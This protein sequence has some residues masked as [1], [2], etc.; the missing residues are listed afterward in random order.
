[1]STTISGCKRARHNLPHALTTWQVSKM[2]ESPLIGSGEC[3]EIVS[4]R[5]SESSQQQ[6]LA[7]GSVSSVGTS[8]NDFDTVGG[9][10][11]DD[12][13]D[14]IQPITAEQLIASAGSGMNK[15]PKKALPEQPH[16][17]KKLGFHLDHLG[18][19]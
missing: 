14:P 4:V 3:A 6:S 11:E 1:M 13:Q 12:W 10:R 19:K 18:R 2:D 7:I 16:Q 17:P 15:A 9:T 5:D 8:S